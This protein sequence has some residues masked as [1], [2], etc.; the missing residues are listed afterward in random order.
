MAFTAATTNSDAAWRPD[1]FTFQPEDVLPTA[2]ILL[3]SSVVG[4]IEGDQPAVR[5]AY[6]DDDNA[7]FVDEGDP[8]D[9]SEP[10]LNEA[11]VYTKKIAQ[12]S[13]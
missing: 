3:A 7:E 8:I 11:V 12:W 13:D 4:R 2:A 1:Q 10:G 6:V 5:V 9:E